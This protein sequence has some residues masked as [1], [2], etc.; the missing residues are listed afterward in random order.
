M[1]PMGLVV[2]FPTTPP[3]GLYEIIAVAPLLTCSSYHCQTC[4]ST[5]NTVVFVSLETHNFHEGTN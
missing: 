1:I 4:F 5:A 3:L 2:L